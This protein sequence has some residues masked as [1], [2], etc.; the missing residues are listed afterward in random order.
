MIPV[1]DDLASSSSADFIL[2]M[3]SGYRSNLSAVNN[4]LDKYTAPIVFNVGADVLDTAVSDLVDD[5]GPGAAPPQHADLRVALAGVNPNQPADR[6]AP[7][8]DVLYEAAKSYAAAYRGAIS[9]DGEVGALLRL[10]AEAI[11]STL[12]GDAAASGASSQYQA[13]SL[14][15]AAADTGLPAPVIRQAGV[16]APPHEPGAVAYYLAAAQHFLFS[17]DGM[18]GILIVLVA[19]ITIAGLLSLVQG[20]RKAATR[21]FL[22]ETAPKASLYLSEPDQAESKRS[23]SPPR[24]RG[25]RASDV[26]APLDSRFRG[27]DDSI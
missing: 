24:K 23:P 26:P 11:H 6:R 16:V 14:D 10:G 7:V 20:S 17:R 8:E 4:V 3:L 22:M 19:Y 2:R 27:N 9:F 21:R 18:I 1:D 13:I 25:S 5:P 12:D 15:G